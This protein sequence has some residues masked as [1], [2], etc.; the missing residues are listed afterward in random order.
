MLQR[1]LLGPIDTSQYQ[2]SVTM[3]KD[4]LSLAAAAS[5]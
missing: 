2:K 1:D 4:V 3:P 5:I